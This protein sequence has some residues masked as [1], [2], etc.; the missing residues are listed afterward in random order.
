MKKEISTFS[1]KDEIKTVP[2]PKPKG[3]DVQPI[4]PNK[5]IIKTKKVLVS[6]RNPN[7]QN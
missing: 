6:K 5:N 4:V 7:H 3:F 1:L 2:M